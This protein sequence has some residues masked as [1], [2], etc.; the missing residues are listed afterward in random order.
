MN[1]Y[2]VRNTPYPATGSLNIETIPAGADIYVDGTYI[3][4]SPYIVGSLSPGSH[5]LRLHRSG[6]DEYI[7]PVTV[8]EGRQTPVTVRFNSQ[9]AIGRIH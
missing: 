5:I 8:T 6:Y 9:H 1:A 4:E 2:L 3:A 7:A